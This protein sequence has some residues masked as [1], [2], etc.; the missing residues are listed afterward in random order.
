LSS[1]RI[2]TR[3]YVVSGCAQSEIQYVF[4]QRGLDVYFNG[5]YGCPDSK[6]VIMSN[7]VKL[8]DMKY[9]AVFI[10]DSRYDYEIA[11]KFNIDFIFVSKY[12]EFIK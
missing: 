12:S 10:G 7:I 8:P 5:I 9:P 4:K 2:Y 3:K 11:S 1:L 6:E